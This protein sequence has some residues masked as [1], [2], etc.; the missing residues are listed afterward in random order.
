MKLALQDLLK[1]RIEKW[2]DCR[3]Y[4]YSLPRG[5]DFAYDAR[6]HLARGGSHVI[7][8]VGANIGQSVVRFRDW[9]PSARIFSFEPVAST[10]AELQKRTGHLE[11]GHLSRLA[12]GAE[13]RNRFINTNDDPLS[14]INSFVRQAKVGAGEMVKQE[15]LDRFGAEMGV[16]GIDLLQIDVEGYALDV[17]TGCRELLRGGKVKFLYI[18]TALRDDE[19]YFVPFAS[20]D[21]ELRPLGFEVFGIYEQ[22]P[23]A[24][25]R[26]DHL[27]FCNIAYVRDTLVR[28]N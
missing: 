16:H 27:Y 4:R 14:S 28:T 26:R 8:D 13:T 23:D 19:S 11:G 18:E 10:Y 20:L 12:M 15:T 2:L 21:A 24:K 5:V 22:Q 25:R 6:K 7:F 17:L 9:F 3:I 1:T